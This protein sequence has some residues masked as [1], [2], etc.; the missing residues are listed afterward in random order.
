MH[1]IQQSGTKLK[2]QIT[3]LTQEKI[4]EIGPQSR[5]LELNHAL[6][7]SGQDDVKNKLQQKSDQ[8]IY[9]DKTVMIKQITGGQNQ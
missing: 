1:M 5:N 8:E 9:T 4:D 3:V 6:L 2:K 7:Q